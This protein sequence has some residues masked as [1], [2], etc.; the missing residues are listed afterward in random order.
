MTSK[1]GERLSEPTS[2]FSEEEKT[3]T[4][5]AFDPLQESYIQGATL[6]GLNPAFPTPCPLFLH[7]SCD[8]SGCKRQNSNFFFLFKDF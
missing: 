4:C 6:F 7:I 8:S 1:D 3:E 2:L 5:I